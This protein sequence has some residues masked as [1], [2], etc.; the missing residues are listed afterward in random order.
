MTVAYKQ[1]SADR[2]QES[3]GL[4]QRLIERQRQLEHLATRQ[5]AAEAA[6]DPQASRHNLLELGQKLSQLHPAD[7]AHVLEALPLEDRLLAWDLTDPSR[8]GAVL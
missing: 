4:V 7:I 1:Q 2:L 3:L 5:D 6:A 8:D